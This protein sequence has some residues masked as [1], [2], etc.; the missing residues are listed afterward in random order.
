M[1]TAE[2]IE[3][4]LTQSVIGGFYAVY[5]ELGYGF[6]ENVYVLAMERELRKRGHLV[7]REVG[8]SIFYLG[9]QLCTYRCD[10][11]VDDKLISE[12]KPGEPLPAASIRQ[13]RNYLKATRVEVGLLLH[14]GPKPKFYREILTQSQIRSSVVPP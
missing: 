10:M 5:T 7:R 1:G 14:F 13:L 4:H 9:E 2:L 12:I 8:I 11:I 3:G 6:L